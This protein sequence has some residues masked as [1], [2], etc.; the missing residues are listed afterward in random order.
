MCRLDDVHI[1]AEKLLAND[2]RYLDDAS[3]GRDALD[4]LILEHTLGGLPDKAFELAE[5]A[6][7]ASV[8]QSWSR[9]IEPLRQRPEKV[10]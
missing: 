10:A 7:G 6:Y 8:R 2:D 5:M 4:L 1:V 9:A 3:Q